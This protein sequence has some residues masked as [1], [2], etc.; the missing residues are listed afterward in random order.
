MDPRSRPPVSDATRRGAIIVGVV[1]VG[2]VVVVVV[3]V[4]VVVLLVRRQRTKSAADASSMSSGAVG[5]VI[6]YPENDSLHQI[7]LDDGRYVRPACEGC[8]PAALA[9]TCPFA[10]MPQTGPAPVPWQFEIAS[11][12]QHGYYL[13]ANGKYATTM[14]PFSGAASACQHIVCFTASKAAAKQF[15]LI[16]LDDKAGKFYVKEHGTANFVKKAS[17][18]SANQQLCSDYGVPEPLTIL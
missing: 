18:Q 17:A 4:I 16:P 1:S 6:D 9:A 8:N 10:A 13:K 5:A 14:P 11:A 12:E 7:R 2:T 3:V 15:D